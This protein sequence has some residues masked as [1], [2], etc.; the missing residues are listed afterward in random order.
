MRH[1]VLAARTRRASGARRPRT[2]AARLTYSSSPYPYSSVWRSV[3]N[4][5]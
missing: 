3:R 5:V 2:A 1:S 4:C